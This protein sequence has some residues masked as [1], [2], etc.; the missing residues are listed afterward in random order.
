MNRNKLFTGIWCALV[1]VGIAAGTGIGLSVNNDP[2]PVSANEVSNNY[3]YFIPNSE[4]IRN[5]GNPRYALYTKV[6]GIGTWYDFQKQDGASSEDLYYAELDHDIDNIDLFIFVAM[7]PNKPTNGW[8]SEK[9]NQSADITRTASNV[10][11]NIFHLNNNGWDY[12]GGTWSG[13][14]DRPLFEKKATVGFKLT[15]KPSTT[16]NVQYH[17]W[18]NNTVYAAQDGTLTFVDDGTENGYW[19]AEDISCAMDNIQFHVNDYQ[20]GKTVDLQ[21]Q[22][23]A[24]TPQ[25]GQIALFT[26]TDTDSSGKWTGSWS[27]LKPV[28][29]DPNYARIWFSNNENGTIHWNNHLFTL[30]YWNDRG[31]DI[32][33][34]PT[35][36]EMGS[37]WLAAFDV[38]KADLIYS[39]MQFKIYDPATGAYVAS[40]VYVENETVYR[41]GNNHHIYYLWV[42]DSDNPHYST[43]GG[44]NEGNNPSAEQLKPVLEAYY[45]CLNDLDNGFANIDALKATWHM[46]AVT[47]LEKVTINDYAD[48]DTNYD[49]GLVRNTNLAEKIAQMEAEAKTHSQVAQVRSEP[50]TNNDMII[51]LVVVAIAASAIALL[52]IYSIKR[53]KEMK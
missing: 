13:Y 37:Q 52:A 28:E 24:K 9:W 39:N 14:F 18:S 29:I 8:G 40:T 3:V 51:L 5:A 21:L 48:E 25:D 38:L 6:D 15:W 34:M 1:A 12:A 42:D 31:K 35:W 33:V 46:D 17:A 41:S 20:N 11:N 7:D 23:F 16:D 36:Y 47:G 50:F 43:D 32:E 30:H 19:L 4:W 53:R 44:L 2:A 45:T 27:L 22:T 10:G 26:C 49:G